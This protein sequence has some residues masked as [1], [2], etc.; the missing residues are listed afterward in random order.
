M[1][2]EEKKKAS[3]TGCTA[4]ERARIEK[5]VRLKQ[6]I[7]MLNLEV[8]TMESLSARLK[9]SDYVCWQGSSINAAS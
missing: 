9:S 4:D 7:N 8:E 5:E 6:L 3:E 1:T 2:E